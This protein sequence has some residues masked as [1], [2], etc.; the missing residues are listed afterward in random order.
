MRTRTSGLCLSMG[1]YM[2]RYTYYI[3]TTHVIPIHYNSAYLYR[4]WEVFWLNYGFIF[5][6]NLFFTI[7]RPPDERTAVEP[8]VSVDRFA[9][10]NS[11]L[12]KRLHPLRRRR[13]IEMHCSCFT[14]CRRRHTTH[15]F[16]FFIKKIFDLYLYTCITYV[17]RK[18]MNCFDYFFFD[19]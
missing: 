10:C 15:F 3:I 4:I 16:F 17:I 14:R 5:F 11:T 6:N 2:R 18:P 19:L 8:F 13:C 1:Y 12:K 7:V 9:G